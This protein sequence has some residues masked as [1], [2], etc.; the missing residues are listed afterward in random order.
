MAFV[1]AAGL[2]ALDD[3]AL[4]GRV[5]QAVEAAPKRPGRDVTRYLTDDYLDGSIRGAINRRRGAIAARQVLLSAVLLSA[6][7]P[8][9]ER[10]RHW[11]GVALCHSGD[12]QVGRLDPEPLLTREDTGSLALA[13][14]HGSGWARRRWVRWPV[15][16]F[17]T[18]KGGYVGGRPPSD[19]CT[20]S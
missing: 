5:R 7:L 15:R 13:R 10:G 9:C 4:K 3:E 2:V 12:R 17:R 6:V 20:T 1:R 14:P 16:R 8:Y 19:H 18:S 11:E